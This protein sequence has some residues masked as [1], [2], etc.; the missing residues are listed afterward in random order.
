MIDPADGAELGWLA[1]S[2][3]DA[4]PWP[5]APDDEP[6]AGPVD[7]PV[8]YLVEP[9]SPPP[10]CGELEDWVRRPLEHD[11]VVARSH[12]LVARGREKGANLVA[13][14]EDGVLRVGDRLAILSPL[15]ARLVGALLASCGDVVARDRVT[16][17]VWPDGP[18][19]D[20]RALDNR[21]KVVRE[22][23]AGL[24]LRIH[25]VRGRGLLLSQVAEPI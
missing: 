19:S 3:V 21:V 12:R 8:L 11:E 5:P 7:H 9:W 14:D 1:G 20:A 16:A 17:A 4:R 23:L 25:T 22:R 13:L 6:L 15:E 10:P 24:P 18:P 2:G